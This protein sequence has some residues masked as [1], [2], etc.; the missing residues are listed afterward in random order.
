MADPYLNR[1]VIDNANIEEWQK[2]FSD[3]ILK[4]DLAAIIYTYRIG[5]ID[6]LIFYLKDNKYPADKL[7]KASSIY[8]AD[9]KKASDFLYYVGFAK[10]C[11]KF[12]NIDPYVWY[13]DINP[14]D[15]LDRTREIQ[16]LI[17]SGQKQSM[18]TGSAFLKERYNFQRLR[19]YFQSGEY[20]NALKFYNS[21]K[22]QSFNSESIQFRS[23]GY[24]AGCY[25]KK[26]EYATANYFYSLMFNYE[27]TKL[28]AYWSF[29]PQENS[30]WHATLAM[31]KDNKE[32]FN[33]WL[34][35]GMYS[36]DPLYA[37][38]ELYKLDPTSP[39]LEEILNSA[40][41]VTERNNL[42]LK[43][44]WDYSEV[45]AKDGNYAFNMK[46]SEGLI[47]F[48]EKVANERKVS[49]PVLWFIAHGYLL[50]IK[51]DF[52]KA[53]EIY[54]KAQAEA[55]D[56]IEKRQIQLFK[57]INDIEQIG[58]IG[59]KEEQFIARTLSKDFHSS[60]TNLSTE[61]DVMDWCIKR[62]GAKLL[63]QGD[64][65]KAVFFNLHSEPSFSRNEAGVKKM[66][67]YFEKKSPTAFDQLAYTLCRYK[68]EELYEFLAVEKMYKKD[69][70]AAVKIFAS[71]PG[72]G[73][74]EFLGDPFYARINDCHDCDHEQ[75]RYK[76]SKEKFAT[77]MLELQNRIKKRG[78][79]YSSDCFEYATALYNMTYF[80]NGRLIYETTINNPYGVTFFEYREYHPI[81]AL[82]KIY[83]CREAEKYY[84]E[85]LNS[86][87]DDEFKAK[88]AFMAAKCEQ[89]SF[90][91]SKPGD[92]AGDFQSGEFFRIL[93]SDY[94]DTKYYK[95][96][97]K[98]CGYFSTYVS[99]I[100]GKK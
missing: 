69:F 27:P 13:Y 46:I 67:S 4:E 20:D 98:E 47:T 86:S 21:F 19:L 87:T 40:V 58:T 99:S 10:R 43:F 32:R 44:L 11:E 30:D 56:E 51:G 2:F 96:I 12:C 36:D 39:T 52:N 95:E 48:V 23:M 53:S 81:D 26:R 24:A 29:H 34:M 9:K 18:N 22:D 64:T 62:V 50:T 15:T 100:A 54:K 6:T 82:D 14:Q 3:T 84:K 85:A 60:K 91:I 90:L 89:N 79:S 63:S 28:S 49:R 70:A 59:E 76:Y 80:G 8:Q 31:A 16:K 77:K 25:Y 37:L 41:F 55:T 74:E 38:E 66:I 7:L 92:F 75:F 35:M 1:D 78:K 68:V 5:Q 42:P 65:L 33:L 72:S 88:C 93:K 71:K 97:I 17:S 73:M 45:N 57:T 94:A 83:D 61:A